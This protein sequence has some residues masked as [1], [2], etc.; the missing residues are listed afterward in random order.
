MAPAAKPVM[1]VR[2][3]EDGDETDM[4]PVRPQGG[5]TKPPEHLSEEQKQL[6]QVHKSF[7]LLFQETPGLTKVI[8]LKVPTP[9][10]QRPLPCS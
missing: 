5:A 2:V 9:M 4:E 7:T 3:T 8:I 1:M 10:R 6:A